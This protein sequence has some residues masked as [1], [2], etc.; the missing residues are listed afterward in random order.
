M[1]TLQCENIEGQFGRSLSARGDAQHQRDGGG[2]CLTTHPSVLPDISPTRGEISGGNVVDPL[3][4]AIG[5]TKADCQSPLVR[6]MPGRT[7]GTRGITTPHLAFPSGALK[8]QT[9]PNGSCT[10]P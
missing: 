1:T 6:G 10:L 2:Q 9:W 8:A 5:E 3:E 4:P 7:E